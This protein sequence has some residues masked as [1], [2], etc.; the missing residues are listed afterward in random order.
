MK[1]TQLARKSALSRGPMKK[2]NPERQ[3]KRRASYAKKLAAYRRS[4]TFIGVEIRAGNRCER[5]EDYGPF[6]AIRCFN[7]RVSG[8]RLTHHHKTYARFGGQELMEDVE[9]LCEEHH[10]EAEAAHPTRA[11]PRGS[12]RQSA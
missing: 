11:R 9:L 1:R 12:R 6:R 7:G 3:A 5:V 2:V 4:E 8:H 10:A